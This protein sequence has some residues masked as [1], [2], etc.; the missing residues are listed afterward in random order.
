MRL[1]TGQV[2]L[3]NLMSWDEDRVGAMVRAAVERKIGM[4][5]AFPDLGADDL[6]QDLLI[7][8]RGSYPKF[9][10]DRAS[11]STFIGMICGRRLIDI[12]R[13]RS[14]LANREGNYAERVY[15][16][17][18]WQ[19]KDDNARAVLVADE[20]IDPPEPEPETVEGE[21]VRDVDELPLADWL[22]TIYTHAR[23]TITSAEFRIG[24]R[25]HNVAQAVA[26]I[27]LQNRLKLST[28][29][30]RGLYDD[31]EDLRRA[32]QFKHVPDQ[33]WFVRSREVASQF[34]KDAAGE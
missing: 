17:P 26:S 8:C 6:V 1:S 11:L 7:A 15:G 16:R 21:V 20:V 32:V 14:R 13:R 18:E 33:S 31:R 34:L 27:A 4:F 3:R 24:R 19:G 9:D 30:I 22:S 29:G 25:S 10:P 28:R 23:R 2:T 5:A 12:Y